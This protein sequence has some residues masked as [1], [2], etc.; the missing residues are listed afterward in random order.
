MHVRQ[1]ALD[2]VV[3]ERQPLMLNTQKVQDGSVQVVPWNR[4]IHAAVA[5]FVRG[6]ISD[7]MLEAGAGQPDAEAVLI[8]VAAQADHVGGGLG[9]GRAAKFGSEQHQG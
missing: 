1:T 8:M 6:A 2:T 5:D 4:V 7:A 9:E 3:I